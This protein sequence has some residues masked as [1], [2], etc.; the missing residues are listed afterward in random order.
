[1]EK[2][3]QTLHVERSRQR[4]DLAAPEE[5]EQR[6]ERRPQ[7]VRGETSQSRRVIGARSK[8]RTGSY[9]L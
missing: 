7:R 4:R 1:M 8:A 2:A 5:Q 9:I 3:V 6:W